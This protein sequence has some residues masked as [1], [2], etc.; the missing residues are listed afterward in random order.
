MRRLALL[1]PLF[2]AGCT[3]LRPGTDADEA[4]GCREF[5]DAVYLSVTDA[6]GAPAPGVTVSAT[7]LRTGEVYGPC[8]EPG[9]APTGVL[10]P[11]CQVDPKTGLFSPSDLAYYKILGDEHRAG[12]STRGDTVLVRGTRGDAAFATRMVIEDD[13]CHV[14]KT[15][16]L[17]AVKL[18]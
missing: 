16:G 6:R 12:L 13:G 5:I 14:E 17:D 15:W 9:A 4:T 3:T 7:N 2:L 8:P 1:L 18:R 11:G 10:A